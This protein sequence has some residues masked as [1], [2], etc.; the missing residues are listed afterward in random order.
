MTLGVLSFTWRLRLMG[1]VTILTLLKYV[2][3]SIYFSAAF[4]TG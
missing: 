3:I 1:L 2:E 4:L